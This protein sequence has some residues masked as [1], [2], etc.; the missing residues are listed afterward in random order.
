MNENNFVIKKQ[1]PNKERKKRLT[2]HS[3][4]LVS[5]HKM[6]GNHYIFPKKKYARRDLNFVRVDRRCKAIVDCCCSM[7][8]GVRRVNAMIKGVWVLTIR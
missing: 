5:T 6:I 4:N 7:P 2:I 1:Q 3:S 8:L